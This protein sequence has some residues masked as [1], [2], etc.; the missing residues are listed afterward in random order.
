VTAATE[1]FVANDVGGSAGVV[2][3]L[4]ILVTG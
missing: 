4:V 2:A 3:V 1:A